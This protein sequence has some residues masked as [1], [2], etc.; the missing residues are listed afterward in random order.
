MVDLLAILFVMYIGL[1]ASVIVPYKRKKAEGKIKVFD[2]KFLWH[3]IVTAFWE[4][5]AGL[6]LYIGWN[7]PADLLISDI[8]ILVVAFTFGYGGLEGQK[9]LEKVLR[10]LLPFIPSLRSGDV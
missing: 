2:L 1:I 5:I 7:P 4:F 6:T 3:A 8:A 9:Q 10:P